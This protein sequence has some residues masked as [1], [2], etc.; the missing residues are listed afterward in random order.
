[1]GHGSARPG[2]QA[3]SFGVADCSSLF[4]EPQEYLPA[5]YKT[6][7]NV[8]RASMDAISDEQVAPRLLPRRDG[9]LQVI[10][11][12][13]E[14]AEVSRHGCGEQPARRVRLR[15]R[16]NIDLNL[17][18]RELD[19][20]EACSQALAARDVLA[21]RDDQS[22]RV[23]GWPADPVGAHPR[24]AGAIAGGTEQAIGLTM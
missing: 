6:R 16:E 13:R 19:D 20:Q 9:V 3:R 10:H 8:R 23:I 4:G 14:P 17:A 5:Q 12:M 21:G 2:E 18:W 11:V 7:R 15:C 1:M 24:T 22:A